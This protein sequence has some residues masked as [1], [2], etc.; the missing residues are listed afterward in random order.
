MLLRV[1]CVTFS[2]FAN[3]AMLPNPDARITARRYLRRP[4]TRMVRSTAIVSGSLFNP[5]TLGVVKKFASKYRFSTRSDSCHSR[6][7]EKIEKKLFLFVSPKHVT[8]V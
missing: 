7:Y 2:L 5:S 6:N 8:I 3:A 1:D 4:S